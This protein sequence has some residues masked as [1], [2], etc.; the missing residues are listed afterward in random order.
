MNILPGGNN[1]NPGGVDNQNFNHINPEHPLRHHIP[2]W[3]NGET[4]EFRVTQQD[5]A[6]HARTRTRL[7]PG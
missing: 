3:I 6:N 4:F 7:S 2:G 5:V 1:G